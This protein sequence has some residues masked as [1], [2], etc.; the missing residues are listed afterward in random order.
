MPAPASVDVVLAAVAGPA[1]ASLVAAPRPGGHYC[2][3]GAAGG[4]DIRFDAWNLIE[5]RTLTGYSSETLTGE[6][7]RAA[8]RE[9][10]KLSLPSAPKT[11][12]PLTEARRA[13]SLLEKREVRGRILL[14]P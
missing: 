8:T 2:M 1:F 5:P 14:I 4:G 6:A 9:L 12:L 10:L 7:L 3:Y 11:L 13:H